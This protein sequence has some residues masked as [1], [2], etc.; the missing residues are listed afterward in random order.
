M[1]TRV[2]SPEVPSSVKRRMSG[3]FRAIVE[4]PA[5]LGRKDGVIVDV[6]RGSARVRHAGALDVGTYAQLT[7]RT[8]HGEF[9]G[10]AEVL[11]CRVVGKARDGATQFE[12][13]VRFSNVG[14]E[15]NAILEQI[16]ADQE[17]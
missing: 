9:S 17:G 10:N 13:L 6:S 14:S 7:F 15:G 11:S 5:R 3:R 8:S 4:F 1:K 12:S 16:V 2:Q